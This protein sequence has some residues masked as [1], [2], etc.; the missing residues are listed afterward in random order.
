ME[1]V[2]HLGCFGLVGLNPVFSIGLIAMIAAV[3]ALISGSLSRRNRHRA[4][5]IMVILEYVVFF[6]QT[7]YFRIF[8]QPLQ[9]KAMLVGGKDAL[10][11]YWREALTG[12]LHALPLLLLMAVPLVGVG[13]WRYLTTWE[14]TY[15]TSIKKLRMGLIAGVALIYCVSVMEI[16]KAL[17]AL[18]AEEYREFYD[19]MSV[20]QDMGVIAMV[21]RDGAYELGEMMESL[22]DKISDS[23][24]RE[25]TP[26]TQLAQGEAMGLPMPQ[27]RRE[28]VR[29]SPRSQGES[30]QRYR[31]RR[32]PRSRFW[33]LLPIYGIWIW[34]N[35]RSFPRAAK[36]RNGWP[37]I[38]GR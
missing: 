31:S 8:Q 19:P 6:V 32:R 17:D 3:Q 7:V 27:M 24:S 22:W 33:T 9:I 25:E 36:K 16:G 1:I 38:W 29:S 35:W 14:L 23:R 20:M 18:Y 28:P 10:T 13:I 4:F 30:L 15:L 5:W 37:I 11:N 34:R 21:Q 12:L 26:D 2:F